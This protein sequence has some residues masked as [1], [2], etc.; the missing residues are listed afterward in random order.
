MDSRNV[1]E[2]FWAR[3]LRAKSYPGDM[4]NDEE[5]N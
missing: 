1:P 2:R 4:S 5:S 3:S